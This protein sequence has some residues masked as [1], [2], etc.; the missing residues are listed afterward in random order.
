M[1]SLIVVQPIPRRFSWKRVGPARADMG[2]DR[3]SFATRRHRTHR[4]ACGRRCAWSDADGPVQLERPSLLLVQSHMARRRLV[5]V[6][7]CSTARRRLGRSGRMVRLATARPPPG[8]SS[9]EARPTEPKP[10]ESG[11]T[12]QPASATA[13]EPDVRASTAAKLEKTGT[14]HEMV[15]ACFR[16][17]QLV[18]RCDRARG[19]GDQVQALSALC[20]GPCEREDLRM[21]RRHLRP[22]SLLPRRQLVR[23]RNGP[24][25]QMI[26]RGRCDEAR[27][28]GR[29]RSMPPGSKEDRRAGELNLGAEPHKEP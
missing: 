22:L 27:A 7:L 26:P 2:R 24:V 18:H 21:P 14:A 17:S 20:R 25:S 3:T 23:H 5:P 1:S 16:A 4:H 10:A 13:P 15:L 8:G 12:G 19:C 9:V 11:P 29:S 6:R 28:A